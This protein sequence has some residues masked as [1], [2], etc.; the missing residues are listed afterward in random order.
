LM[1]STLMSYVSH[2]QVWGLWENGQLYLGGV[3]N[4]AQVS[5][6]REFLSI[7]EALAPAT[8]VT[9]GGFD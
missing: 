4:R 5:F 1:L 9:D 3:T 7:L 6:E 2:S 8:D